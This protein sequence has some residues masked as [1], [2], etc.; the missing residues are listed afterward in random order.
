MSWFRQKWSADDFS[1]Q[2]N[3]AASHREYSRHEGLSFD[4]AQSKKGERDRGRDASEARAEVK[5]LKCDTIS[6]R[7]ASVALRFN[8]ANADEKAAS[9]AIS[10]KNRLRAKIS[11]FARSHPFIGAYP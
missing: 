4:E 7:A 1:W 3:S 6:G 5:C 9:L 11:H 8:A 10:H 2:Q